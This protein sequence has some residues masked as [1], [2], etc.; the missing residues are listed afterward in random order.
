MHQYDF[1]LPY[2]DSKGIEPLVVRMNESRVRIRWRRGCR[3]CVSHQG[4][5]DD[6]EVRRAE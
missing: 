6:E 3:D 5:V 1:Q 4:A 2:V